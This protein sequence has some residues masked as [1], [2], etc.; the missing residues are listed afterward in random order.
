MIRDGTEEGVH[1]TAQSRRS[2]DQPEIRGAF[3][4]DQ[5]VLLAEF[6]RVYDDR[7]S[8]VARCLLGVDARNMWGRVSRWLFAPVLYSLERRTNMFRSGFVLAAGP[9]SPNAPALPLLAAWIEIAWT[10]AL[11]L[12]D[13]L[14][15]S[16]EREGHPSAHV[17][18]GSWRS[19]ASLLMVLGYTFLWFFYCVPLPLRGRLELARL[20]CVDFILCMSSQ[21][22]RRR[23][24]LH[25]A[26]Y[27]KAACNVNIATR[28]SLL[29]PW[30]SSSDRVVK[31]ALGSYAE[32]VAIAA[33]MRNDLFDY[34]GGSSES[35]TLFKDFAFRHV[36]FPLLIFFRK[37][38][39]DDVRKVAEQYFVGK[40]ELELDRL[41]EFFQ[42]DHVAA[43]SLRAIDDELAKSRVALAPLRDRPGWAPLIAL[44]DRWTYALVN[45]CRMQ[46]ESSHAI[47]VDEQPCHTR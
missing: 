20:S 46:L 29:A 27:R 15:R 7:V 5:E 12:D 8:A 28:W 45:Y 3:V 23:R 42:Q 36:S 2:N 32:H 21:L 6:Q 1:R 14:D 33:K 11:M 39:R 22:V 25:M 13:V 31:R 4:S 40:G 9:L 17:V 47:E 18:Y 43:I 34:Y 44:L 24:L 35:E 19:I 30:A 16:A 26:C 38:T 10:C 37:E 41:L